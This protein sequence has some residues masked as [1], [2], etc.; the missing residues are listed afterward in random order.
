MDSSLAE[1]YT[2]TIYGPSMKYQEKQK[3]TKYICWPPLGRLPS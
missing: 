2:I 1:K 3:M